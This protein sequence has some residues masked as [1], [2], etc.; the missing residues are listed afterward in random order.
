MSLGR[1]AWEGSHQ[2]AL[3]AAKKDLPTFTR[4]LGSQATTDTLGIKRVQRGL[5]TSL[6]SHY[7]KL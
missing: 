5:V 4:S 2:W 6:Q 1:E 7:S 3:P